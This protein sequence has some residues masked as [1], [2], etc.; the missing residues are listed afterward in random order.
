MVD[1]GGGAARTGAP[2]TTRESSVCTF[3][4]S[5]RSCADTGTAPTKA[6]TIAMATISLQ[7][8]M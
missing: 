8:V 1:T 6:P 7:T 4:V 2:D 3:P 5:E